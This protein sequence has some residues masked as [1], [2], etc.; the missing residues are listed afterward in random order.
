[1]ATMVSL[2]A[3]ASTRGARGSVAV[4][5]GGDEQGRGSR[6]LGGELAGVRADEHQRRGGPS[7]ELEEAVQ[8]A[9]AHPAAA[10]R[11]VRH[12]QAEGHGRVQH[13]AGHVAAGEAAGGDASADSEGEVVGPGQRRA[14]SF[15]ASCG[16]HDECEHERE[17]ELNEVSRVIRGTGLRP[18][19]DGLFV[20]QAEIT[21]TSKHRSCEL[22]H[23]IEKSISQGAAALVRQHEGQ[24]DSRIEVC[25]RH[26]SE[27]N[28]HAHQRGRC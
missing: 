13:A 6:G 19:C 8:H 24:G 12:R 21:D 10:Q 3:A 27:G 7:Q 18:Q 16:E 5:G 20:V 17:H 25:S 28:H 22:E 2:R 26:V 14:D 9:I 11:D 1:M 4:I 23:D 15:D